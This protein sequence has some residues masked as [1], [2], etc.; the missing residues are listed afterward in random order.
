V[1]ASVV[2]D[3]HDYGRYLAEAVDSALGQTH[4]DV[5]VVVVD[6]GSTDDSR[7]VIARYEGRVVA[8]LKE[9]GGQ[10]SAFNAGFAAAS[11]DVVVFL[12]ADDALLPDTVA[13]AVAAFEAEPALAKVQ[14]RLDMVDGGGRPLGSSRPEAHLRMPSGDLRGHVTGGGGYTWPPTSGNAF[15]A[16]A[17]RRV[18]PMPEDGFRVSAD[19]YLVPAVALLG[20]V[21]S[22]GGSGGRYRVHDANS[23]Y[24]GGRLSLDAVRARVETQARAHAALG[25]LAASLGLDGF[26]PRPAGGV[27]A[28]TLRMASRKLDPARHPLPG[29]RLATVA[30]LGVAASLA[31]PAAPLHQRALS[32]LWFAGMPL[33][34]RSLARRAA[35]ARL[36]QR[37]RVR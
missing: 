10:A 3:N 28:L 14:W 8:V 23:Y 7:D 6:D 18:L 22:L 11:G 5:E 37:T 21:R 26:P 15:A 35:D 30:R 16:W 19:A 34:P 17:L 24:R 25:E 29:D 33:L 36:A 20:P 13:R 1:R 9:N 32:A 2:V 31:H 12:D 4:A 27:A